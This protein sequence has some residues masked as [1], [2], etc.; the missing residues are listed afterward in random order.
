MPRGSASLAASAGLDQDT[1]LSWQTAPVAR[2]FIYLLGLQRQQR[3][4][5]AVSRTQTSGYLN[6]GAGFKAS[7]FMTF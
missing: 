7:P 6:N 5:Q 4:R 3:D 1:V 2:M